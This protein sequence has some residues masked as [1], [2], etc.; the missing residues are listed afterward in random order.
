MPG[1]RKPINPTLRLQFSNSIYRAGIAKSE[2]WNPRHPPLFFFL[3][4]P[5][6]SASLLSFFLFVAF[7]KRLA[8]TTGFVVVVVSVF[9]RSCRPWVIRTDPKERGFEYVSGVKRQAGQDRNL[10]TEGVGSVPIASSKN[11]QRTSLDGLEAAVVTKKTSKRPRTEIEELEGLLKLNQSAN[12]EGK[13]VDH[14]ASIRKAFRYDRREKR[15]RLIGGKK[16]GWKGGMALLEVNDS[17]ILLS[18]ETS[19]GRASVEERSKLSKVRKSSIFES[20]RKAKDKRKKHSSRSSSTPEI[21]GSEAVPESVPSNNKEISE[22]M[23]ETIL[24][25]LIPTAAARSGSSIARKKKLALSNGVLSIMGG[26]SK[27]ESRSTSSPPTDST[28]SVTENTPDT[29]SNSNKNKP[30]QKTIDH[31]KSSLSFLDLVGAY[32][33]SD[34]EQG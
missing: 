21:V 9:V 3:H 19:Y 17:D 8:L 15:K 33:S 22:A 26:K 18:K 25:S 20:S 13:D 32:G 16:L 10:I 29:K 31:D 6:Y 28:V 30:I 4:I 12:A 5:Y 24:S 27:G 2:C 11:A 23:P 7:R 14:N 1:K 34:D